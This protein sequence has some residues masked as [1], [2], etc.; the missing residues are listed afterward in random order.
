MSPLREAWFDDKRGLALR[1]SPLLFHSPQTN[2][3]QANQAPS[4]ANQAPRS[5]NHAP[6]SSESSTLLKRIKHP[7]QANQAP[8]SANHAPSSGES[9]SCKQ[10]QLARRKSKHTIEAEH[11]KK[12]LKISRFSFIVRDFSRNR[13]LFAKLSR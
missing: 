3:T 8:S 9:S 11:K 6:S 1:A 4:S 5:A 10:R 7:A 13:N 2:S 12:R